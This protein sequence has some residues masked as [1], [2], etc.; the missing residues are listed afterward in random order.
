MTTVLLLVIAQ[1]ILDATHIIKYLHALFFFRKI[2]PVIILGKGSLGWDTNYMKE[3]WKQV[4][5]LGAVPWTAEVATLATCTHLFLGHPW[6]WGAYFFC[7]SF[8]F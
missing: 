1:Q 2:Y 6:L 3:N 4:S 7:C 8:I 5:A